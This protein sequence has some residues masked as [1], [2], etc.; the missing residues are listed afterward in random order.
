MIEE[1]RLLA[2][3][4]DDDSIEFDAFQLQVTQMPDNSLFDGAMESIEL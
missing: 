4:T 1:I 3:D 2:S